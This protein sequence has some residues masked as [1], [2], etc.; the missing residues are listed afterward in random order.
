MAATIRGFRIDEPFVERSSCFLSTPANGNHSINPST[1]HPS[2]HHVVGSNPLETDPIPV[3]DST[4]KPRVRSIGQR[5][6]YH[7]TR[8]SIWKSSSAIFRSWA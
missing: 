6:I 1:R 7:S 2:S 8:C 4:P 5:L 3:I